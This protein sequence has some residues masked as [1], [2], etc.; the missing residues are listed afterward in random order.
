MTTEARRGGFPVGLTIA[1]AIALAIL[2]ALGTWQLQRL[3]WKQH[4][5]AQ[6]AALQAAPA[7]PLGSALDRV[8][9]GV[10]A[11]FTR[12]KVTCPGIATAP[13][14]ELYSLRDGQAG[15][16]LISACPTGSARYQTI[17]VDRGF[18][19]DTVSARPPVDAAGTAPVEVTGV[20]RVP[21]HGNSFTPPNTP[22]RWYTRDA[23]A[24]AAA[25]KAPAPAPLFLMAETATNPEWKALIPAPIPAEIPNRHLEYALTW[26]G[27][28]AALLGVY[29]AMLLR[30]RKS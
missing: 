20:L 13:Y 16:R 9:K 18:V 3:Q 26:Y 23:P 30:K 6:I 22:T 10:D 15:S 5:L 27:L 1:T 24:M 21:E 25:L 12:V 17:L 11:D 7:Q 4:L 28:A 29:A 8:A 2:L 14:V 19:I